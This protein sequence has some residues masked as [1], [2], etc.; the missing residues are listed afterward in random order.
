MGQRN[1]VRWSE[2]PIGWRW[3]R[4]CRAVRLWAEERPPVTRDEEPEPV[5]PEDDMRA[6][7]VLL[8]GYNGANN[9]GA[10][11][12]L[13]ADIADLRAVL[14][15]AARLTVPT[16]NAANLRRYLQP[17]PTLRIAQIPTIFFPAVRR[18]VRRH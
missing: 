15:P 10:E 11:A 2:G 14:G 9:T 6:P 5:E 16:L 3:S 13:Q 18:L 7:T 4:S 1:R 17:S 8:V 12:L